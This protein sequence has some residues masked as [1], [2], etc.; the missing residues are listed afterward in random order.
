MNQKT[1]YIGLEEAYK[2]KCMRIND[3]KQYSRMKQYRERKEKGLCVRCGIKKILKS[4]KKKNL[5]TC[6][7]CRIEIKKNQEK[8]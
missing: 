4:Q 5:V 8:E 2:E 1:T 6:R 3:P 7:K